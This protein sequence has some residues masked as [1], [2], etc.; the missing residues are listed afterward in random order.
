MKDSRYLRLDQFVPLFLSFYGNRNIRVFSLSSH[1][2]AKPSKSLRPVTISLTSQNSNE[3]YKRAGY[4][5]KFGKVMK[6]L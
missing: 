6:D 5:G 1:H 3:N 4:S 2:T